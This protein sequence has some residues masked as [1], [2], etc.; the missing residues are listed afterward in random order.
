MRR[1]VRK[2]LQGHIGRNLPADT[3]LST[4]RHVY[5]FLWAGFIEYWGKLGMLGSSFSRKVK[6]SMQKLCILKVMH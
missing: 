3:L 2:S 4:I 5:N 1:N 6:I